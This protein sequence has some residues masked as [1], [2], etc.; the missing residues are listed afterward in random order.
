MSLD[1]RITEHFD[2]VILK[3]LKR[4]MKL[5]DK[6]LHHKLKHLALQ[7]VSVRDRLL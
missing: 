5:S 2:I 1:Y 6:H 4:A 7:L 3:M